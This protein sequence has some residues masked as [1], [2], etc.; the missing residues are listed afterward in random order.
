MIQAGWDGS[1]GCAIQ[2][3]ETEMRPHPVGFIQNS[4]HCDQLFRIIQRFIFDHMT[5][6]DADSQ[7]VAAAATTKRSDLEIKDAQLIF[8]SIWRQLERE[9]GREKMRYPKEIILLGGAPGSVKKAAAL[10]I[11]GSGLSV[12]AATTGASAE[13][14][15]LALTAVSPLIDS[16]VALKNAFGEFAKSSPVR[17]ASTTAAAPAAALEPAPAAAQAAAQS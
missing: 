2:L 7:S 14:V 12:A 10:Q 15:S 11:I 4:V 13:A 5:S 3:Q 9:F 8:G 1:I 16:I 6:H 17:A